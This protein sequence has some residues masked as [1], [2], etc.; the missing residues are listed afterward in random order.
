MDS[1]VLHVASLLAPLIR[2]ARPS[3]R[4]RR[5]RR[6]ACHRGPRVYRDLGTAN[7]APLLIMVIL[8]RGMKDLACYGAT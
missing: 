3:R 7:G 4:D 6:T 2:Y 1:L 5:R 8:V